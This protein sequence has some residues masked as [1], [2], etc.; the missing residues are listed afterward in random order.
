MWN[1]IRDQVGRCFFTYQRPTTK[2]HGCRKSS[3]P[4]GRNSFWHISRLS[5]RIHRPIPSAAA[6]VAVLTRAVCWTIRSLEEQMNM[7]L[8][9][10]MAGF[11]PE[12]GSNVLPITVGFQLQLWGSIILIAAACRFSIGSWTTI[13]RNCAIYLSES[14]SRFVFGENLIQIMTSVTCLG[15]SSKLTLT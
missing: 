5:L 8:Q 6:W 2:A 13:H 3:K 7:A 14:L 4:P 1:P 15:R 11:T 12:V 10:R 9:L